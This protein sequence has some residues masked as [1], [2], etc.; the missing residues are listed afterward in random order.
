MEYIINEKQD[1]IIL[2][3]FLKKELV[4]SARLIKKLKK[5]YGAITVNGEP[6]TVRRILNKDDI[7]FL[8]LDD[9]EE[10][11]NEYLEKSDIPLDILY[12][13]DNYTVINKAPNMPTH[14]SR[15][16]YTGTLANALAFRYQ[17][18]PYIFRAINRLD[19]DTSGIVLTANNRHFADILSKKL[20]S[21]CFHKQY[22]AIVEGRI[23]SSGEINAPIKREKE[24]I[25]K[26]IVADDG[27]E[28][29]TK[30]E[31]LASCDQMS[32]LLVTPITGR[33]HQIRVHMA[34]LGHPII[35]D[36]LYG[37]SCLQIEY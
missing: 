1:K 11:T 15:G 12:E 8:D 29:I 17:D 7:V 36:T 27:D 9:K 20:R 14:Q 35:G 10:E 4:L 22:I 31:L 32:V 13:D 34:S 37:S 16:H 2:R 18:R 19:K 25:I 3:D 26:R 33:T 30:Y 23:A 6:S 21:G 5:Y 24:S 28:A